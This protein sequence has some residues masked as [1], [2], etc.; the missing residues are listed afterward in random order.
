MASE[1]KRDDYVAE[2]NGDED[3]S[4][5]PSIANNATIALFSDC[6][7]SIL[8]TATNKYVLSGTMAER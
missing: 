3:A 6:G 2:A 4:P 8:L 7:P 5:S 1:K